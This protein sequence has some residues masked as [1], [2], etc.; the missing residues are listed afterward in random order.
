MARNRLLRPHPAARERAVPPRAWLLNFL[1]L[2]AGCAC[3]TRHPVG[4][5]RVSGEALGSSAELGMSAQ[6]VE[7]RFRRALESTG[8]FR[9]LQA[10]AR[11]A[12]DAASLSLEVA[13]AR[14]PQT[15][16]DGGN[17]EVGVVLGIRR[18]IEGVVH[19][20]ELTAVGEAPLPAP[21]ARSQ[22]MR[23]ALDHALQQLVE[24]AQLQ[25]RA[26]SR[27]DVELLREVRTGNGSA[28]EAAIR[29][30]SHRQNH[31][32]ADVLIE[33]LRSSGDPDAVRHA[34]GALSAMRER[35]AVQPLI[36][37]T[38]G[39]DAGFVREVLFAVAQ[40]GGDEAAA[41]LFTVAQGHDDEALR[42]AARRALAE[43]EKTSKGV[44]R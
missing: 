25:L 33:R 43:M 27:S 35:R 38:R 23:S 15:G 21:E 4:E 10:G 1:L 39:M 42:E 26:L 11:E 3:S 37:L 14:G 30:L 7:T 28:R 22:A 20:Y 44:T 24:E 5:L 2:V 32:V 12:R 29:V 13:V 16:D 36:E 17:A 40:I 8:R 9:L 18:R 41:W 19:R 31:E 6:E 34:I